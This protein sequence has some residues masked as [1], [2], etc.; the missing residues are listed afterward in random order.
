M[1]RMA[2]RMRLVLLVGCNVEMWSERAESNMH[3]ERKEKQ[4]EI[5]KNLIFDV[6]SLV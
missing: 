4:E 5:N 2:W 3:S 1:Y 6:A